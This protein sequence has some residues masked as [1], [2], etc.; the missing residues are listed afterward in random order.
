MRNGPGVG[1]SHR[2]L[3]LYRESFLLPLGAL[4][5]TGAGGYDVTD[6][7]GRAYFAHE[8][9]VFPALFDIV[10]ESGEDPSRR[11]YVGGPTAEGDGFPTGDL[12]FENGGDYANGA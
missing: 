2:L 4:R 3:A 8:A 12:R 10:P 11:P 9:E 1:V 6:Q 5:R 7:I